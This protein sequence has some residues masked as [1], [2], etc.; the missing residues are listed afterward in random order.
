MPAVVEGMDQFWSGEIRQGEGERP[1]AVLEIGLEHKQLVD[2]VVILPENQSALVV[3]IDDWIS[4]GIVDALAEVD[5][6][7][8]HDERRK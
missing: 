2:A 6:C 3:V 5:A 8:G 7:I 4:A 1:N